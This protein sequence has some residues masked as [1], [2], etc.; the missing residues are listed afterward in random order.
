VPLV[1]LAAHRGEIVK[2]LQHLFVVKP[3]SIVA[4]SHVRANLRRLCRRFAS[5]IYLRAFA[6]TKGTRQLQSPDCS[7]LMRILLGRILY[8]VL[9]E[10]CFEHA[11][12]FGYPVNIEQFRALRE[13]VLPSWCAW[14]SIFTFNSR[15]YLQFNWLDRSHSIHW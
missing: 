12:I 2:S 7:S 1:N 14:E 8:Y 11:G 5:A 15:L 10:I 3:C 6:H 4:I 9:L 13:R